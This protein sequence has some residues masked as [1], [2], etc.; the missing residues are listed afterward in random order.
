MTKAIMTLLAIFCSIGYKLAFVLFIVSGV[1]WAIS[2]GDSASI[3]FKSIYVFF[4]TLFTQI[5]LI[6][7]A[8]FVNNE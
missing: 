8:A 3:F 1:F 7:I 5:T 4:A 2:Y 6:I